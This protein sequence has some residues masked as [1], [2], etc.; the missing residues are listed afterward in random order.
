[1]SQTNGSLISWS[2]LIHPLDSKRVAKAFSELNSAPF[3]IEY[4]I[5]D[6]NGEFRWIRHTLIETE[7]IRLKKIGRGFVRDIQTEKELEQESLRIS[8][9]E[10]NRIG[11]DLHDDLCQVLAGV[12]CLMRVT[13]G[14]IAGKVPEEVAS[15]R[16]L[17]QQIVDAMHR[18]RALTHGLFPGK[19]QIADVR[20]A[21][22]E[23]AAQVRARFQVEV[24]TE[25]V[26]RFPHHTNNQII[27]V[28]RLA[29]EAISNAIKHGHATCVEVRLEARSA[30]ML[31]SITDNGTGLSQT[32]PAEKGV[33]HHI[34][35]SRT[36]TLGGTLEIYNAAPKGVA[37]KLTYPFRH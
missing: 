1:M 25:F 35:Q 4:R 13:E 28:Y 12:S 8:E 17:N 36:R 29:Q 14:R 34:M 11:Q 7:S 18:T 24:R 20:G 31:L 33:G 6:T 27:Q 37:V 22:L 3:S 19:I 2:D 23:L 32:E 16:E 30:N 15:L 21:L 9:R 26:G 5:V 10:Q